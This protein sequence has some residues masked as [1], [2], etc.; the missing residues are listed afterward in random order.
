MILERGL[1]VIENLPPKKRNGVALTAVR[2]GDD[3]YIVST[4]PYG[5]DDYFETGTTE[6]RGYLIQG[7]SAVLNP[8][9]RNED[10]RIEIYRGSVEDALSHHKNTVDGL[11][12]A[13]ENDR[14]NLIS[15]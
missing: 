12:T 15:S 8:S 9:W 5:Q 3:K 14:D 1:T 4:V 13:I 6:L 2:R 10:T 11:A 7:R